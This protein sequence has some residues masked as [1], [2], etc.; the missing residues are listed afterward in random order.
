MKRNLSFSNRLSILPDVPY[1]VD[2]L[3]ADVPLQLGVPPHHLDI[4]AA[5]LSA[6]MPVERLLVSHGEPVLRDGHAAL[7]RALA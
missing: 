1:M 6:D 5:N 3:H 2:E 4:Q 7:A